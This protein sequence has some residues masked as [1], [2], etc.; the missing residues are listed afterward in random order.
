MNGSHFAPAPPGQPGY[1][2]AFPAGSPLYGGPPYSGSVG[3][4]RDRPPIPYDDPIVPPTAE[5][6]REPR[7]AAAAPAG[8]PSRPR[9]AVLTVTVPEDAVVTVDG[10]ATYQPGGRRVFVTPRIT[11]GVPHT[12]EL[13]ARWRGPDGRSVSTTRRVLVKAGEETQAILS[14]P[15]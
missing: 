5:R 6:V 13:V 10:D 2:Y 9:P 15:K 1:G 14:P 11:P 12:L 4:I 8:P 3:R 7:P